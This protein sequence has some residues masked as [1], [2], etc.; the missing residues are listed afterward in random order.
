M[1][2]ENEVEQAKLILSELKKVIKEQDK[3]AS[4][5]AAITK[6]YNAISGR[7]SEDKLRLETYVVQN[8][9]EKF[10]IMLTFILLI[11]CQT[12]DIDLNLLAREIIDEWIMA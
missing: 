11:S 3:D 8:Y 2:A 9:L 4:K 7:A 6:L 10:L 12:I 5:K 1:S